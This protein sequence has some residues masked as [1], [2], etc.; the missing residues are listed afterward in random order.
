MPSNQPK[1]QQTRE[2]V[3]DVLNS[4]AKQTKITSPYEII[5][6]QMLTLKDEGRRLLIL[7]NDS[8][9]VPNAT[10]L[11]I[12]EVYPRFAKCYTVNALNEGADAK[13][14]YTL[15]YSEFLDN[16][17]KNRIEIEE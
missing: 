11:V 4:H 15:N 6:K 8:S 14:P 10:V 5:E 2:Y 1:L 9:L 12:D 13:I 7:K 16:N 17:T 3:M